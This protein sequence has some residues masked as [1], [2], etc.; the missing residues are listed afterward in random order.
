MS[1]V[2]YPNSLISLESFLL[3]GF[4]SIF[5]F[6]LEFGFSWCK[7]ASDVAFHGIPKFQLPFPFLKCDVESLVLKIVSC[8]LITVSHAW[9]TW[10]TWKIAEIHVLW[11]LLVFSVLP[12]NTTLYA[13][14]IRIAISALS[15]H[16]VQI[17]D[18]KN[19][20][21]CQKWIESKPDPF[22][23]FCSHLFDIFYEIMITLCYSVSY[24]VTITYAQLI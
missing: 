9:N 18:D 8:R 10:Y 5:L 24:H 17:A 12:M 21:L 16:G 6:C 20:V 2:F 3:L 14:S 15:Y 1:T 7:Y 19:F 22:F 13:Y 23:F 11:I 4:A